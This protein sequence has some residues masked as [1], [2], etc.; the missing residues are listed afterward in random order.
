MTRT[1]DDRAAALQSAKTVNMLPHVF[2][3]NA[4]VPS[5]LVGATIVGI[6]TFADAGLVEGG[7]L[8]IDYRP[9]DSVDTKRLVLGFN[10]EAMWVE[11]ESR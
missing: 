10:D 6:G 8:V 1:K 9:A 2:R 7:G 5:S 11:A 4:P 3:R